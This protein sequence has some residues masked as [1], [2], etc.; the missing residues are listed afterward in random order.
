MIFVNF[1]L[2]TVSVFSIPLKSPRQGFSLIEAAI[3]LALVGLVLGGLWIARASVS[4]Q[5]V[6]SVMAGEVMQIITKF[7]KLHSGQSTPIQSW[8]VWP[9]TL[10]AAGMIP[11]TWKLSASRFWT[12]ENISFIFSTAGADGWATDGMPAVYIVMP[13]QYCPDFISDMVFKYKATG[14]GLT[15]LGANWQSSIIDVPT[16]LASSVN[17]STIISH[18]NANNVGATGSADYSLVVARFDG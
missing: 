9:S 18:C 10:Q 16:V 15:R 3:I 7:K 11:P 5:R 13:K 12:P 14:I 6:S 2:L 1:T 8:T 17:M 4:Q